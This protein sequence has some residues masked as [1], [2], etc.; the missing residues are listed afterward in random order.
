[1]PDSEINLIKVGRHEETG[2]ED[3]ILELLGEYAPKLRSM[4]ENIERTLN[5]RERKWFIM[6]GALLVGLGIGTIFVVSS[7][8]RSD[9]VTGLTAAWTLVFCT[10]V[11]GY[12]EFFIAIPHLRHQLRWLREDIRV[13]AAKVAALVR[14]ASPRAERKDMDPVERLRFEFRILEAEAALKY[15]QYVVPAV[16]EDIAVNYGKASESKQSP[17]NPSDESGKEMGPSAPSA[18]E[19]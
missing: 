19:H 10:A 15:A 1:M 2:H 11:A 7:L 9:T 17:K 4:C 13:L 16:E 3:P 12:F 5:A 14:M 18:L 8:N 6:A